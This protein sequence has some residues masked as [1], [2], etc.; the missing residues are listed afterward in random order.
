MRVVRSKPDKIDYGLGG[1]LFV[2]IPHQI[3]KMKQRR[4]KA[5]VKRAAESC[6]LLVDDL[7]FALVLLKHCGNV[8]L[9]NVADAAG[10]DCGKRWMIQFVHRAQRLA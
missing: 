8:I 9:N 4:F 2:R 3:G 6:R 1:T 10:Y 7:R 5:V